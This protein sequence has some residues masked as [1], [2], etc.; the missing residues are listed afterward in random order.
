MRLGNVVVVAGARVVPATVSCDDGN[1][2][3]VSP[4]ANATP[5]DAKEVK[6]N[7]MAAMRV[8]GFIVR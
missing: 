1:V 6:A 3:S 2:V 5:E 7:V 8:E 4:A